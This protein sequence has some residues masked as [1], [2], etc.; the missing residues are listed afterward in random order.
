MGWVMLVLYR[1]FARSAGVIL[2][3][4]GPAFVMQNGSPLNRD[5]MVT[6]SQALLAAARR[7]LP[8]STSPVVKP[9]S[10]LLRGVQA[11]CVQRWMPMSQFR[12]SWTLAVGVRWHGSGMPLF[13]VKTKPVRWPQCGRLHHILCHLGWVVPVL[14]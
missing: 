1:E 12:L 6:K 3:D 4:D 9:Q 11:G 2:S 13:L 8:L 5:W 14:P 10:K 7:R